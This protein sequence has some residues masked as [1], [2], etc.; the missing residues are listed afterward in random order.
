MLQSPILVLVLSH[1]VCS[2][3]TVEIPRSSITGYSMRDPK[4]E[5]ATLVAGRSCPYPRHL[6]LLTLYFT[7][8]TNAPPPSHPIPSQPCTHNEGQCGALVR[9]PMRYRHQRSQVV[10][11]ELSEV[12]R[13]Q[14]SALNAT[15]FD[16]A[17]EELHEPESNTQPHISGYDP[18][19]IADQATWDKYA[20]R[21]GQLM[22]VMRR[23]DKYA[24]T[25]ME[26]SRVPPSA[27]SIWTG[28]LVCK[29]NYESGVSL[30]SPHNM[31]HTC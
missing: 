20:A 16:N 23:S 12:S 6:P 27:E 11:P 5:N 31:P 8:V 19:A 25:V 7:S 15:K 10:Q 21:G 26:D 13:H 29:F 2:H 9:E 1:H 28:D 14:L 17:S 3:L 24:G 18:A 4:V 22:C 30:S